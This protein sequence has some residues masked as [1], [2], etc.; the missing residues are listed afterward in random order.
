MINVGDN[1]GE[2][3]INSNILLLIQIMSLTTVTNVLQSATRTKVE[4]ELTLGVPT[5]T[6]P[7]L[8]TDNTKYHYQTDGLKS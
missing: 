1:I 4:A 3:Q 5:S 6:A 2:A 7:P 8:Y